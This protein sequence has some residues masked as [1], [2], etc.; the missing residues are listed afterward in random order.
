MLFAVVSSTGHYS[1]RINCGGNEANVSGTIYNADTGRKGASMFYTSQ[2][3]ALSSTGSFM[4]N[5]LD[6]DPYIVTNTSRL[7]NV[8]R[9]NSKLYTTARVSPL[10]LTYYGLCMINGNYTVKLHFAEIIFV[11]DRSFNS[12]GRR[13]FD[14]YIQVTI[15]MFMMLNI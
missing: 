4:D 5:D 11:N 13:I 8:S 3:W 2:D 1:L 15:D 7:L 6:S 10:S 14:V 12:L 9:I